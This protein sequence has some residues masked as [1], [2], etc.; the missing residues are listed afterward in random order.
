MTIKPFCHNMMKSNLFL[1]LVLS[2]LKGVQSKMPSHT[3]QL[4]PEN[5]I[6]LNRLPC[7]SH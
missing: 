4:Y 2:K 6:I 3:G 5:N 1:N 7:G